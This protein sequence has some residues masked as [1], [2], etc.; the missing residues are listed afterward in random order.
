MASLM[1]F[2]TSSHF[3]CFYPFCFYSTAALLTMHSAVIPTAIPYVRLSIGL[4]FCH[5][6]V[7]YPDEWRVDHGVF[8]LR[9]QKHS[10]FLIPTMVGGDVPFHL[11]F[12][13]K[14]TPS[15]KRRLRPICAYNVSTVIASKKSSTIIIII[16]TIMITSKAPLTGA[17]R[18]RTVQAYT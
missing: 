7:P 4:S 8:P 17:Q 15:E 2:R 9:Y 11:K 14:L 3:I 13:L 16:I 1:T 18:R 6:L 12:A 10:S 5:T